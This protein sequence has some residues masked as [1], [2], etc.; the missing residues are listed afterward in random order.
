VGLP[1]PDPAEDALFNPGPV[2]SK[3]G[4]CRVA[5]EGPERLVA[6]ALPEQYGPAIQKARGLLLGLRETHS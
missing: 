3:N 5:K 4:M 6:G 1:T 2:A